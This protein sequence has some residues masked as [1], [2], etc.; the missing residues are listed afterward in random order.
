MFWCYRK[1]FYISF[2]EHIQGR[3][4]WCEWGG[5]GGGRGKGTCVNMDSMKCCRRGRAAAEWSSWD[6]QRIPGRGLGAQ[7]LE[8]FTNFRPSR[9]LEI[10]LSTLKKRDELCLHWRKNLLRSKEGKLNELG[11][12]DGGNVIF[13]LVSKTYKR[14]YLEINVK[15]MKH[16]DDLI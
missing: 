9:R 11:C 15:E 14:H 4:E 8:K 6:S 3:S 1:L 13:W 16:F 12:K 7:P 5:G 2:L 10:A